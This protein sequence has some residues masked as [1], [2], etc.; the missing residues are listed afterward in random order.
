[1]F[2][3]KKLLEAL[4][5]GAQQP[6]AQTAPSGGGS[7]ADVLSQVL[8]QASPSRQP[9]GTQGG[10]DGTL[11]DIIGR[12]GQ[13]SPQTSGEQGAALGGGS[14]ADVLGKI[15]GQGASSATQQSSADAPSTA[16]PGG[17]EDILRK[18]QAQLGG[19]GSLGDIL[20]QVLGQAT[21][22]VKEGAR[23]ID[24]ATGASGHMRD[25][26]RNAT[27]RD[28]NDILDQIR[29]WV[30]KN[31]M[32]AGAVAGGLGAIVLGTHAGRS[33]AGSAAKLGALAM[34]GGLA[35][36]ALQN[37]QAG[38]PLISGADASLAEAPRGSGFESAAATHE[39]ALLYIRGMIAAAAADGRID[40]GEQDK[41]VDGLKQA[42]ID[43]GAE[44]FLAKELNSP[45][46]VED[47]VAGVKN[48]QQAVQLFTAA[49]IVIGI[50]NQQNN[51]FLAALGTALGLDET[52]IQ[53]ID[54]VARNAA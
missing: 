10:Q 43:A 12:M 42:G 36:K 46:T 45:A 8:G 27:G 20:G 29:D 23:K 53:H 54:S 33:L 17:L 26:A 28:P 24:D 49:R 31:Q 6:H 25:A 3:A 13:Q 40:P 51:D 16:N 21:A 50:D 32:G 7:L 14:L 41:I 39:S 18:V 15:L 35:Y 47:L 19:S 30:Q 4:M 44:E 34:I 37:Y 2:D 9:T 48:E 22:G 38:R 1:M 52:L 11:G 5:K